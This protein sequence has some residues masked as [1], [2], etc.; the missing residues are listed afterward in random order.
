MYFLTQEALGTTHQGHSFN[1]A[2]DAWVRELREQGLVPIIERQEQAHLARKLVDDLTPMQA[3]VVKQKYCRNDGKEPEEVTNQQIADE[4]G[5]P[6]NTVKSHM[7]RGLEQLRVL[8]LREEAKQGGTAL[9]E[10]I[11][12]CIQH[13]FDDDLPGN[14]S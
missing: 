12:G 10:R 7:R 14:W 9:A 13:I 11:M 4:L 2:K 5:L 6:L 3:A 8:V 1:A